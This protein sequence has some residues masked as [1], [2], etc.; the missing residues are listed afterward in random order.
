[1]KAIE[2]QRDKRFNFFPIVDVEGNNVLIRPH[3]D[4]F[5]ISHPQNE[6]E[7]VFVS[8]KAAMVF[9]LSVGGK[10]EVEEFLSWYRSAKE[11]W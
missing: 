11:R 8:F 10:E 7:K 6:S 5:T 1:M 9:V 4:G 2:S 3:E